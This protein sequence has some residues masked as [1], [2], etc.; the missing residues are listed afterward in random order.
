M[1]EAWNEAKK[2]VSEL[3]AYPEFVREEE[4]DKMSKEGKF[5]QG[6]FVINV[7]TDDS[8]VERLGMMKEK[9]IDREF[10]DKV[11]SFAKER[12]LRPE[13]SPI[14]IL[15]RDS[16]GHVVARIDKT[17]FEASKPELFEDMGKELYGLKTE[18]KEKSD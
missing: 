6:D 7:Y 14:S 2:Y 10:Y 5:R 16:L 12:N 8:V 9:R 17:Y 15:L 1:S 13:N 3:K 4:L 11:M 18:N